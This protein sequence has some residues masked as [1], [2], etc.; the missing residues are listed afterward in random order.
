MTRKYLRYG[1][2]LFRLSDVKNGE[3][4]KMFEKLINKEITQKEFEEW[5]KKQPKSRKKTEWESL[6]FRYK[7]EN[8]PPK[9]QI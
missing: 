7:K 4:D 2:K 9:P 1:S 6:F 5:L 8:P 3:D